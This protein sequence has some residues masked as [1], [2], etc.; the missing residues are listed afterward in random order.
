ML[1]SYVNQCIRLLI[2]QTLYCLSGLIPKQHKAVMGCYKNKFADNS[3]YLFL[4]WQRQQTITA[5]WI[6]G[7]KA[8]IKQ[9]TQQGYL[10]YYRWS[11]MGVFHALTAKYYIYNSYIGDI[12]Q[13][14]AKGAIKINLWH[15]SPLKQIEFDIS[16]GPLH[17][18][19]HPST[20]AQKLNAKALYHQQ[21]VKPDFMLAASD[22]VKGLF[23]TGFK[24]TDEQFLCC[25]N[26]R[27]DY[28][29]Y[30]QINNHQTPF[31]NQE[32]KHVILYAPSWRDSS[33][34]ND[35]NNIYAEAINFKALSTQLIDQN[36]ILL[37][38]LHPNEA[39]F[40][41]ELDQYPNIIN[42]TEWDDI[43]GIINKIDLL[44]TDYS[45]IYIDA[46]QYK[47]DIAFFPFD[48]AHYH[49][50][51]RSEYSYVAK[52]P[53]AGPSVYNFAELQNM[54]KHMATN[55]E[56]SLNVADSSRQAF[57]SPQ[58][59]QVLTNTFWQH[60]TNALDCLDELVKQGQHEAIKKPA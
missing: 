28:H 60:S 15:G 9:L 6:S 20:W 3:K 11:L 8:L 29:R 35:N 19:Y 33:L 17:S 46:L 49:S 39:H 56:P 50:E 5:I 16:N 40:A 43:Y 31:T 27:T 24:M 18:V 30:Y 4:H 47:C 22:T 26:P 52:L 12:N 54:L 48:K 32:V 25:G 10:A 1:F 58:T 36:Q 23:R 14:F 38:R 34:T 37:L 57:C 55:A 44:I 45:S 59:R 2:T 51:C 42:I 41:A 53:A 13:Y 7:D 21:Y